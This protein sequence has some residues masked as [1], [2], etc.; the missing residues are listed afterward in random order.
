MASGPEDQDA[1]DLSVTQCSW[2]CHMQ[3][4]AGDD[5]EVSCV[6]VQSL[7]E[8]TNAQQQTVVQLQKKAVVACNDQLKEL[9]TNVSG[10]QAQVRIYWLLPLSKKDALMLIC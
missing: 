6:G 1:N 7:A 2:L 4:T 10:V 5:V 9:C 3:E 8:D